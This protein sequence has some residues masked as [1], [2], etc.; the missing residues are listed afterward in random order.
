MT[1][2]LTCS[3]GTHLEIDDKFAGQT[4][5]CPD[6]DR[7]LQ[8]PTLKRGPLRT[9]GLA[10]ASFILAL[11]G[12]FTVV[13]TILAVGLA[14][15]ALVDIN[16]QRDRLAGRPYAIAGIVLGAVLTGLSVFAY[17]SFELFGL[18]SVLREPQ[19]A[20]KLDYSGRLEIVRSKEGFA[21]T[22]PSEKWGV[23][24][25]T[26]FELANWVRPDLLL[27]NV[28]EDG[29]L[30][31]WPILV[32]N[33]WSLDQCRERALDDFRDGD[34]MN[35]PSRNRLHLRAARLDVR[36]TKHLPTVNNT[37]GVEILVD[38]SVGGQHRTYVVRVLKRQGDDQMYLVAGGTSSRRFG[39]LEAQLRK[40]LD[41]FR[42][43]DRF[44]GNNWP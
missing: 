33:H 8:A 30:L 39:R 41:S 6:C 10:L 19:W 25:D 37:E 13:G 35:G 22:R 27:V 15:W 18:D 20:G 31:V 34:L 9:S 36:H 3:C 42:I 44:G 14:V 12:A 1:L 32:P 11:V 24:N 17:V 28:A 16:R 5:R 4:I 40:G 38:K 43:L 26:E 29:Y 2:A 21:I 7:S 23:Y